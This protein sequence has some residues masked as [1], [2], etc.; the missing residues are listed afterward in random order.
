MR[1]LVFFDL[2]T[3]TDADRKNYRRF[4]KAL[5]NEGFLMIQESVYV[6]I[7]SSLESAKFLE[8]RIAEHVP[9]KG[10]VQT[11]IITEKQYTDIH[12]LA[13]EFIDD[14]RNRDERIIVI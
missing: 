9:E 12:F 13:G 11:M 2:P 6:R 14:C 10:V 7:A 1:L 5:I 3:V 8:S 4:R